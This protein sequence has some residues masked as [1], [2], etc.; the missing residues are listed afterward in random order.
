MAE[1]DRDLLVPTE[2]IDQPSRR[3]TGD[4][5]FAPEADIA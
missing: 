4:I 2:E 5:G 1:D 3:M